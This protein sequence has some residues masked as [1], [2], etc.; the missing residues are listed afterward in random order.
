MLEALAL[1]K[2]YQGTPALDKLDL[3]VP[4]GEVFCLLGPNGAGKTTT[5]NLFLNFIQPTSG[6]ARVCSVDTAASPL[7]AR[8]L[9]A[10]IPETVML[11]GNLTGLENLDYFSTLSTGRRRPRDE[12]LML[13]REAGLQEEAAPGR[14][15]GYSKGM[16]QKVGIA[17]ALAKDAKALLLDE[18]TS[19]LDPLAA[20]EFARLIETLRRRGMAVLMVT[21]DLFLAKQCGNRVGIM[22]RGRLAA[23]FNTDDTDH[24]GLERA[25]IDVS[26]QEAAA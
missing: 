25:Y 10:Y 8:Q 19:G 9:L 26:R 17:I 16:R 15:S 5:V 3:L 7:E 14:V 13:L 21:H 23:V 20:N 12:L 22:Q 11:Y 18:P 1:T 2:I 6:H 24:L 4:G